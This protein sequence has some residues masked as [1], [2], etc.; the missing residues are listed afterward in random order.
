MRRL[1]LSDLDLSA[2]GAKPLEQMTDTEVLQAIVDAAGRR[3]AMG[4]HNPVLQT[5]AAEAERALADLTHSKKD[6]P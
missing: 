5:M 4:D 1:D 6:T 2:R 3:I